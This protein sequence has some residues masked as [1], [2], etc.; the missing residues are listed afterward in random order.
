MPDASAGKDAAARR[1][2][3]GCAAG[4]RFF[5]REKGRCAILKKSKKQCGFIRQGWLARTME[6]AHRLP[7]FAV[8]RNEE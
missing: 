2:N 7:L 1:Y 5:L 4:R 3:V 6:R 8:Q